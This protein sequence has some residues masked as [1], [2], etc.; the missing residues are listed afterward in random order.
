MALLIQG[1]RS[2]PGSSGATN[3]QLFQA[4]KDNHFASCEEVTTV[5]IKA[6]IQNLKASYRRARELMG[7]TGFGLTAEDSAATLEQKQREV[8]PDFQ[9]LDALWG[10]RPNVVPIRYMSTPSRVSNLVSKPQPR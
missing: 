2:R 3:E 7:S 9:E 4:I 10:T 6:K 1:I 5:R 8:C